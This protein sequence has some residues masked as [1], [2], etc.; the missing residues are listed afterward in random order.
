MEGFMSKKATPVGG[1]AAREKKG[2]LWQFS[3]TNDGTFTLPN[4]DYVT[5]LYYPLFNQA[6]MKCSVTPDLKG[7][8]CLNFHQFLTIPQVTEDFHM[9]KASRNFWVTVKGHTPWSA[10]G[11]SAHHSSQKWTIPEPAEVRAGLGYFSV[12]R[13][14]R[15]LGLAAQSTLY[16]PANNDS[17]EVMIVEIEN[18]GKKVVRFTACSA[19]PIFGRGALNLRDH[20]QVTSMFNETE[21]HKFGV[22][23]KPKIIHDEKGHRA[24]LTRYATLAWDEKG[25]PP[26]KIW[27]NQ[28][29]FMGE[30]GSLDNPESV[31]KNN[32]GS[33]Q[34]VQQGVEAIAAMRFAQ[35][36]LRP[37]AKKS[38]IIIRGITDNPKTIAQ[39]IQNY[40]TLSQVQAQLNHTQTYWRELT[41]K[42]KFTSGQTDRDNLLC[43]VALQPFCRK[44]YGN[45]YLPDHDYGR[46]GRGWRDLWSDMAA[47]FLMDP[48]SAASEIVNNLQGV[49]I[50]GTN[51][52]IIG[53][54][55][56]EFTADR[57]NIVRTWC[58]HG[59]WP[60][61][62]LKF[63]IDQTGDLNILQ[64]TIPYWK[65]RVHGRG[66]LRDE[67]WS[68]AL[69]TWQKDH[70][71]QV[72][73][74]SLLEHV[75]IQQ[76]SSFFNVGEHNNILLEGADWNDTY[77]MGK[78]K[79]ES[80]CFSNWTAWNLEL[81]AELLLKLDADGTKT[82]ELLNDMLPLLD[83]LP[84]QTP[85]SYST[86]I[87]KR[88]QLRLYF[89]SVLRSVSGQKTAIACIELAQDLKAK[90]NACREH[91][92]DNEY[93]QTKDKE[94]FF[95]GHYDND[96]Q[97]VHGDHP[98]GVRIDLTSQVMSILCDTATDDQ[99][100]QTVHALKRYLRNPST[101]G[102][103]LSSNLNELKLNFGRVSGFV[104]GWRENGSIWSQQNAMLI[105][106]LYKRNFVKEGYAVYAELMELCLQSGQSKTFPNL[107]SCFRLDGK[108][109]SSYLTGSAAWLLLAQTTQM[110]GVRGEMGN[111]I[112]EPKLLKEQFNSDREAQVRTLFQNK[113]ITVIYHNPQRAEYGRYNISDITINNNPVRCKR[114]EHDA[115]LLLTA[116]DFQE[117]CDREENTLRV[118]LVPKL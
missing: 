91:I 116:M 103:R 100:K 50:D 11:A 59:A 66:A 16:V 41:Q 85:V 40:S 63:Y 68:D 70:A 23:L 24:C 55:P 118:T 6:G 58:D 64:K 117:L 35:T 42:L 38:F 97:R 84:G 19:S 33:P 48:S 76:I 10:T 36:T 30:G 18:I 52:T 87:A 57:N 77:D 43:W 61:F 75:L 45:S 15:A 47:L 98:K 54:K 73:Q 72:Y 39:W 5:G 62:I 51:A 102:L 44:V 7:D 95:N 27:N 31:F 21:R 90:A 26:T 37:G 1:I 29:E 12:R 22:I 69:G 92:R 9:S 105:Y 88:E 93:I 65:D 78:D 60:F 96:A 49:R 101:G 99:V 115:R 53:T 74:G 112:L 111:L 94:H 113:L 108:G 3:P 114:A 104:Y 79:G 106:A 20:R 110:Y 8:I 81:I 46:G 71:G 83:R 89:N 80:V 56:G 67:T 13:T 4:P 25:R 86:P 28:L 109:L 34:T 17:V 32:S 2:P 107:P 82:V 14:H